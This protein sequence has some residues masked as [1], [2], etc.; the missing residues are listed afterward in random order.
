[1]EA[2]KQAKTL[3]K[4]GSMTDLNQRELLAPIVACNKLEKI[5]PEASSASKE[6]LSVAQVL[7]SLEKDGSI[8]NTT[9]RIE[10]QF[11]ALKTL[12]TKRTTE[13]ATAAPKQDKIALPL[14]RRKSFT[15]SKTNFE[16][17]TGWLG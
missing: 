5:V 15:R 16:C 9:A 8:K 11:R 7:D 1:M 14:R 4:K 12:Q 10:P 2:V 3:A 13:S 17:S 6:A